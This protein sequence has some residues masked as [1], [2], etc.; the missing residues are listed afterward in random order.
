MFSCAST[1]KATYHFL[2]YQVQ[3]KRIY[4]VIFYSFGLEFCA[5]DKYGSIF[6][7]LPVDIQLCQYHLLKMFFFSI[8]H[9]GFFNKNYLFIGVW[10]NVGVFNSIPLIHVHIFVTRP[11]CFHYY[12]STVKLE[13]REDDAFGSTFTVHYCIS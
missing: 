10:I 3:C 12:K 2:F 13:A 11:S 4:A 7:L 5:W 9:F 6:I 1:F 8:A